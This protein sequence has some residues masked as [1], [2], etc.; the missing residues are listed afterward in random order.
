MQ[1]SANALYYGDCLDWMGQWDDQS[2]DLI[3]LDPPFN[4]QSSYNILF[5]KTPGGAQFRAFDDTWH[6]DHEAA[7]RLAAYR[8]AIARPAH[9]AIVGLET[10][11][12][13]SGM[14][15]YLTYMAER[16]EHCHRLLKPTGSIYLHCDP[17]ASHYL[18]II[19]DS[20][21][22]GV[23]L[24]M[25]LYGTTIISMLREHMPLAAIMTKS[26]SMQGRRARHSIRNEKNETSRVAN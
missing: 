8:A 5:G 17:T 13:P 2:V 18:K 14:L 22:G 9:A 4:S 16:L 15:S 19:L 1:P 26:Y 11:L 20:I 3:Y 6:W 25:K 21:W 24:G 7:D 10:V 12:G 23:I